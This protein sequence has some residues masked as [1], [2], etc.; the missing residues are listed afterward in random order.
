[1][2]KPIAVLTLT[3][4]GGIAILEI[5]EYEEILTYQYYDEEPKKVHYDYEYN[6]EDCKMEPFFLIGD[7]KYYFNEFMKGW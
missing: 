4:W 5:D 7:T 6:E 1:M 2:N 3:N